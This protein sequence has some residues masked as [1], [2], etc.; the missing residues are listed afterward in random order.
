M[1]LRDRQENVERMLSFYK[2]TKG[3]PFQEDTTHV[4]GQVDCLGALLLMDSFNQQNLDAINRSGIRTGVDSRFIFETTI[5]Q[6]DT[7]V[8]EFLSGRKGN[9]H[10]DDVLQMPLSLAKLSYT[11]NVNDWLSVITIPI[12]ARC[13]DVGIASNSFDQVLFNCICIYDEFNNVH[14]LNLLQVATSS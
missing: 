11:A 13:R 14:C 9:E 7:L 8:A 3:G 6:K 10:G 12:G 1:K 4:R 2:S 5:G